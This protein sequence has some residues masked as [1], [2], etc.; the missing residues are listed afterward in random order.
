MAVNVPIKGYHCR[1]RLMLASRRA[2]MFIYFLNLYAPSLRCRRNDTP[3]RD[4]ICE[5][6]DYCLLIFNFRNIYNLGKV[7]KMSS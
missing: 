5:Y 4:L 3:C 7:I 6:V 2:I 1:E